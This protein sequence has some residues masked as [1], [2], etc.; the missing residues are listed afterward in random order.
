MIAATHVIL[1]I[2]DGVVSLTGWGFFVVM[3]IAVAIISV[4]RP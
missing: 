2:N 1:R 4:G 3:V